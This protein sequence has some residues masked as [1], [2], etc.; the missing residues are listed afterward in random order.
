MLRPPL[1]RAPQL[2]LS[3]VRLPLVR[4]S[5]CWGLHSSELCLAVIGECRLLWASLTACGVECS[6][7]SSQLESRYAETS[8]LEFPYLDRVLG[9]LSFKRV[10]LL[11]PLLSR[12]P[13][14]QYYVHAPSWASLAVH[15][16]ECR[17]LLSIWESLSETSTTRTI[18]SW[19]SLWWRA[20][21]L[22]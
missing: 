8:T 20:F 7:V 12:A 21:E 4:E 1:L 15:S 5:S 17:S 14:R 3:V 18:L 22:A 16:V 13:L 6:Q 10:I 19:A 2:G 11:K 9:F